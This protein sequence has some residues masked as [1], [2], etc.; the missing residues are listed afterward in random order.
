MTREGQSRPMDLRR[1]LR[2]VTALAEAALDAELWRLLTVRGLVHGLP[3]LVRAR[4]VNPGSVYRLHAASIPLRV[5]LIEAGSPDRSLTYGALNDAACRFAQ[6]LQRVGVDRGDRVVLFMHNS[7]EF[8]IAAAACAKLR[9]GATPVSYR[10]TGAELRYILRDA[11]PRA[12]VYDAELA[13]AV[14]DADPAACGVRARFFVGTAQD[15]DA[16]GT[17]M[18]A[19]LAEHAPIEPQTLRDE[20]ELI[21][22]TSGTTG[23][24]KGAVRTLKGSSLQ[25]LLRLLQVIPMRHSDVHLVAGPLYHAL[26]GGFATL[27]NGMG[28]TVV[29]MKRFEPEAFLAT[30]SRLRVTSATAVPTMLRDLAA[31]PAD[32]RARYDL[33]SLR[34][35]VSSGSALEPALVREFAA[36]YGPSLLYNLYGATELGW[37]T[38]ARPREL[39]DRPGT[40]GRPVP[41]CDVVL[42]GEGGRELGADEV[43]ELF[44]RSDLLIRGYHQNEEA[45]TKA[46]M[47]QA[48]GVGDLARRDADGFLYIAGRKV[49]MV[50]SG[51]VNVYPAEIEVALGEHPDVVEAAIIGVQDERWGEA[52]RAFVVPRAGVTLGAEALEAFL[53]ER[54]AGYK[55]PRQ[56]RFLAELPRNPTGKVLKRALPAD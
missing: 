3:E 12:L 37:V 55:I 38:V 46:R 13:H 48:F 51:G 52:L 45:T 33:R 14:R 39:L 7:L 28:A 2:E 56:W 50:V 41:G 31:L 19:A 27:N 21:L 47:G 8:A 49:D 25:Q 54:L 10:L 22:Y 44:V 29:M 1:Q 9:A 23:R 18:A 15:G 30:V 5:A 40:I 11:S 4:G 16:G 53:R 43:G 26:S 36:A 17:G 34:L 35:I 20:P 24:P 6:A 42:M 32:V